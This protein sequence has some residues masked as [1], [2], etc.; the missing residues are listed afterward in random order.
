MAVRLVG[1]VDVQ[2]VGGMVVVNLDVI[3]MKVVE[4]VNVNMV[5]PAMEV[6][7]HGSLKWILTRRLRPW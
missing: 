4:L 1:N 6:I 5:V 3:E 2:L 7:D